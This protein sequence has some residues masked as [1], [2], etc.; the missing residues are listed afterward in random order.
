MLIDLPALSFVARVVGSEWTTLH[1]ELPCQF[2]SALVEMQFELM[3][4]DCTGQMITSGLYST[5]L[6]PSAHHTFVQKKESTWDSFSDGSP[7]WLENCVQ[8][9]L[10][11]IQLI[12]PHC[13]ILH[14][15]F[16]STHSF[17]P[18]LCSIH[19]NNLCFYGK[20]KLS[21]HTSVIPSYV[22]WVWGGS[23][24]RS[25]RSCALY[26]SGWS[27]PVHVYHSWIR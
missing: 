9:F 12:R 26:R 17:G 23:F 13:G 7:K 18:S 19:Y 14:A 3:D 6:T 20:N 10:I 2:W 8:I 15:T 11:F 5:V 25:V 27:Y 22:K 1:D 4:P 24:H 21:P 16:E